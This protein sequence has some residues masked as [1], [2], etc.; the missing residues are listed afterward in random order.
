MNIKPIQSLLWQS[1]APNS[2]GRRRRR[3]LN[4][5]IQRQQ[6]NLE[7]IPAKS[8]KRNQSERKKFI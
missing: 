8:R 7:V 5:P 1:F 2:S 3:R 6:I 4:V